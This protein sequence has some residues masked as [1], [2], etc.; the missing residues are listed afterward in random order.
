M[1]DLPYPHPGGIE[2]SGMYAVPV[3]RSSVLGGGNDVAMMW[4]WCGNDMAT[5]AN[6]TD[7]LGG[8]VVRCCDVA[9]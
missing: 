5:N 4:Q 8:A 6:L 9:R 3:I 1:H 7:G 2:F